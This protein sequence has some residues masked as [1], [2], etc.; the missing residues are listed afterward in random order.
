MRC[1]TRNQKI[2]YTWARQGVLENHPCSAVAHSM[3]FTPVLIN[4]R[5]FLSRISDSLRAA[6]VV[7]GIVP[8]FS[9]TI[10]PEVFVAATCL[11]LL[12][13]DEARGGQSATRTTYLRN[14]SVRHHA[15]PSHNLQRNI[16]VTVVVSVPRFTISSAQHDEERFREMFIWC[17]LL[18][19]NVPKCLYGFDRF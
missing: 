9:F 7:C 1:S 18:A 6:T 14:R 10:T 8:S 2:R 3:P 19:I 5:Y 4:C 12:S 13:G 16:L 15:M 11:G 17:E